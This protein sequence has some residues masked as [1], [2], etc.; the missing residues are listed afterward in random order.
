LPELLAKD[1]FVSGLFLR[2][3]DGGMHDTESDC[4]GAVKSDHVNAEGEGQRAGPPQAFWIPLIS[5]LVGALAALAGTY[6]ATDSSR[7]AESRAEKVEARGIARIYIRYFNAQG[8]AIQNRLLTGG[9]QR[10]R[11]EPPPLSER[12]RRVLASQLSGEQWNSL[13]TAE[14]ALDLV[15]YGY[16]SKQCQMANAQLSLIYANR[17]LAQVAEVSAPFRRPMPFSPGF[18]CSF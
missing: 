8:V 10:W 7:S 2:L 16:D 6:L 4:G 14:L 1:G 9:A 3:G 12:D 5:T 17:A 15:D 11:P 18:D 13:S